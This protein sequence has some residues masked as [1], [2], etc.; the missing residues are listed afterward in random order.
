[1]TIKLD[2]SADNSEITV[3]ANVTLDA[4]G[5]EDLI[6]QLAIARGAMQPPVP[7]NI[8][9]MIGGSAASLL[10]DATSLAAQPPT[11]DGQVVVRLRSEGLGWLGWRLAPEHI[12]ALRD[13]FN[14]Y[15][16]DG[17]QNTTTDR[18]KPTH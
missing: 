6:R 12:Y 9:D 5:L 2:R 3:Q 7:M 17:R 8:E 10:Q 18:K 1:M 14:G 11:S 4:A 15:F 13:F 16:P